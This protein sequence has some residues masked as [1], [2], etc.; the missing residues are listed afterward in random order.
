MKEKL[1]R[2]NNVK[3]S[4]VMRLIEIKNGKYYLE[5]KD[6]KGLIYIASPEE[7]EEI[8]DDRS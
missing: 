4:V 7:L 2:F 8:E 5:N 6:Y 3:H 1:Y